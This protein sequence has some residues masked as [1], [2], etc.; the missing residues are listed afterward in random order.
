M[1]C[2]Y[3]S[4]FLFSYGCG[5]PNGQCKT[6]KMLL[7]VS[8]NTCTRSV[9]IRTKSPN[10]LSHPEPPPTSQKPTQNYILIYSVVSP[11]HFPE[12]GRE[13]FPESLDWLFPN[14]NNGQPPEPESL[15]KSPTIIGWSTVRTHSAKLEG[16]FR[17]REVGRSM[18]SFVQ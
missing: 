10:S 8:S 9:H 17:F 13:I 5:S 11:P 2:K 14:P 18:C 7:P 16:T 6:Y 1:E 3:G 15:W 12:G 4:T